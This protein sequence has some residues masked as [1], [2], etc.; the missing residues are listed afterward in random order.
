MSIATKDQRRAQTA[1]RLVNLRGQA[2]GVTY[3]AL[4]KGFPALV[5]A[6]GVCQAL[7]FAAA[8]PRYRGY[9]EDLAQVV[10]AASVCELL[11]KGREAALADYLQLTREV[12]RAA[13]WLARYAEALHGGG[14]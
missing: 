9:L 1:W 7:S 12:M 8:K 2:D 6:C 3:R 14:D 13:M 10:G 4:S 5:H 11:Q